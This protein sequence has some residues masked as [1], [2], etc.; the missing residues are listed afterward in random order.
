MDDNNQP[1]PQDI[2]HAPLHE[3]A[4]IESEKGYTEA[5]PGH[6]N[7]D[8]AGDL[9]EREPAWRPGDDP[10]GAESPYHGEDEPGRA[11]QDRT[12]EAD[13]I[14]SSRGNASGSGGL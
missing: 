11:S 4:D 2:E 10:A 7:V 3:S 14:L 6:G 1:T 9:N 12:G 8:E 13:D 5:Q